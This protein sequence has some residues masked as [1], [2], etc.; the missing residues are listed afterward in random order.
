MTNEQPTSTKQ[1]IAWG[2]EPQLKLNQ[3]QRSSDTG[4][5]TLGLLLTIIQDD[6]SA[7]LNYGRD[8]ETSRE[9]LLKRMDW[10]QQTIVGLERNDA[11]LQF[12]L[13]ALSEARESL[14]EPWT[15]LETF[16]TAKSIF[17]DDL[18]ELVDTL[19]ETY[20]SEMTLYRD[21]SHAQH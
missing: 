9:A 3:I 15:T 4:S 1:I 8:A 13:E 14:L 11:Q 10:E 2:N 19:T 17:E 21:W 20:E 12:L 7:F 18:Y 5:I 6:R 16:S